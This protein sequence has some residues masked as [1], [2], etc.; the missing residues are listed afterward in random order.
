MEFIYKAFHPNKM[1]TSIYKNI[2]GSW[3]EGVYMKHLK[4][5]PCPINDCA[6]KEDYE[7]LLFMEGVGDWNLPV[8]IESRVILPETLSLKLDITIRNRNL[9]VNDIVKFRREKCGFEYIGTGVVKNHREKIYIDVNGQHISLSDVSILN[10]VG[11]I[12]ENSDINMGI[13][14]LGFH[15]RIINAY[16]SEPNQ[17][18]SHTLIIQDGNNKTWTFG[19]FDLDGEKCAIWVQHLMR[20]FGTKNISNNTF[21]GTQVFVAVEDNKAVAISVNGEYQKIL[22]TRNMFDVLNKQF[23]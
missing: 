6:K 7:H 13:L 20:V 4:R 23:Q 12:F 9:Y 22:D 14:L 2:R 19:G 5:L 3:C 10:V 16:W 15:G 8:P 1:G 21:I 11:N 17:K 18:L